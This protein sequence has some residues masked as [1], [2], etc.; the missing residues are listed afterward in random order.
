MDKSSIEGNAVD[1]VKIALRSTKIIKPELKEGDKTLSWDGELFVYNSEIFSKDNLKTIIPVQV[2]GRTLK[3]YANTHP[4]DVSDL[5]NFKK[6]KNIL[7]FVVQIVNDEYRI[8][9]LALQL[10][11]LE[12]LLKNIGKRKTISL[13]LTCLPHQNASLIKSIILSFI[14]DAEKQSQIIPGVFNTGDLQ[15]KIK[16]PVLTFNI[17]MRSNFNGAD[18]Y[19]SIVTQKP[20]LY[21]KDEKGVEFPVDKF[22]NMQKLVIGHHN[23]IPIFVD[24]IQYYGGYDILDDDTGTTIRIGRQ[25]R[26]LF[27]EHKL[28]LNYGYA[29]TVKERLNTL[30]FIFAIHYGSILAFGDFKLP[31]QTMKLKDNELTRIEELVKF[32]K[33]ID[34]LFKS[35]GIQKELNIDNLT[36][37]QVNNLYDFCQSELYDKEVSLGLKNTGQGVLR[38]NNINIYCFCV[39]SNKGNK[40]YNIFNDKYARYCIIIGDEQIPVSPYVMLA[41]KATETFEKIDNVNFPDLVTSI[42]KYGIPNKTEDAHIHLL[43]KMLLYYDK[44]K[45]PN[46]LDACLALATMLYEQNKSEINFINLTQ[47]VKRK[48]KL[49]KDTIQ[50]LVSLKNSSSK[51]DIKLAC[52]ILLEAKLECEQYLFELDHAQ[53][54]EFQHY[55]IMNLYSQR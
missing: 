31:I 2:K 47:T 18:I 11:D 33:D 10:Y 50:H 16:K 38:L 13:P 36:K 28:I 42:K 4:I 45:N 53:I 6:K 8:C 55:P 44:I 7:Y 41:D 3:K 27:K 54:E 12:K 48:Q 43:L 26:I 21:Y 20:Y 35:L 14:K 32:Y 30:S 23:D 19:S 5:V 25:I 39:K 46:I 40:V 34:T 1:Y 24:N 51:V 29:G 22:E 49:T 52:C 17:D 37:Q 9:Y 15:K